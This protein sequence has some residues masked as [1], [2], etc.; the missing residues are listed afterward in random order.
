MDLLRAQEKQ[1]PMGV[2]PPAHSLPV[3]KKLNDLGLS[4]T[5]LAELILKT[6]FY[7]EFFTIKDLG[8]RLKLNFNIMNDLIDNLIHE[9]CVEGKG[10]NPDQALGGLLGLSNRFTLTDAGKR[11]AFQLIEYDGYVGPAPVTL[12]SYW[13]QVTAQSIQCSE[14]N[15]ED[16]QRAFRGLVIQRGILEQ[17][18]PAL[19]GGK[20]LFLY[21]PSGNGKTSIAFRLGQIWQDAVLIPYALYVEGHVIRIFDEINHRPVGKT[22]VESE[23]ADRRWVLCH[24][25]CLVVGGELTLGMLDLAYH[26][27]LRYYGA[28]LH[29]KANNGIFVIDDFGRQQISPQALL[30]RWILP[31]ENRKDL[32]CLSTGQQF[33][34]PFDQLLVFAT[35]L[36]PEALLDPAFFRRIRAKVQVRDSD[37]SQFKEIFRLTC[38]KYQIDY[39]DETF[40]YLLEK[41]Y[42]GNSNHRA[43]AACHP[44]DLIE[45]IIDYCRFNKLTPLLTKE[46]LDRACEVYF[47]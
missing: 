26:P 39:V 37:A 38:Q 3:P 8:D 21:G 36:E 34:I 46:N 19:M 13:N 16:L 2:S 6:C 10:A 45:Q 33:S 9:R 35:N 47:I 11:R 5:F 42:N 7:L 12:E 24:R 4:E 15:M 25:P 28:P 1:E 43:M 22:A 29:L 30:N 17:L 41:Y 18:G 20:S 23:S 27:T 31:L 44:R 40:E 32:L 14:H